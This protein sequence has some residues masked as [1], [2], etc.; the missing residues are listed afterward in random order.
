MREHCRCIFEELRCHEQLQFFDKHFCFLFCLHLQDLW[1]LALSPIL[2]HVHLSYSACVAGD[3]SA[4]RPTK[5][6]LLTLTA[7]WTF[8]TRLEQA[9]MSPAAWMKT[10]FFEGAQKITVG[11]VLSHAHVARENKVRGARTT[12]CSVWCPVHS[13]RYKGFAIA[14]KR[15]TLK[16]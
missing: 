3:D 15:N 9:Q 1:R 5:P 16:K 13:R 8:V 6:T 2:L 7:Q 14:C 11:T 10:E 12:V 4:K